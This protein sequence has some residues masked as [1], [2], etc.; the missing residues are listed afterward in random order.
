MEREYHVQDSKYLQRK[1][2]KMLCAS[3]QFQ[4]LLFCGPHANPRGVRRLSKHY[5]LRL[6]P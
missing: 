4:A 1:S 6:D 2:V 5:H 3:T